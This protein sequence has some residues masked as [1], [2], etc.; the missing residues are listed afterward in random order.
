M[1][2]VGMIL[3]ALCCLV[4]AAFFCFSISHPSGNSISSAR[5]E[6]QADSSKMGTVVRTNT[7]IKKG[8]EITWDMLVEKPMPSHEIPPFALVLEVIPGAHANH[9]L[10]AGQVINANDIEP[11]DRTI[12]VSVYTLKDIPAGTRI[13]FGDVK[14]I[15][16]TGAYYA[17]DK[18]GHCT[19]VVGRTTRIRL[20][21]GQQVNDRVLFPEE[22]SA[23]YRHHP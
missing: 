6:L 9:D 3:I 13:Q 23:N 12:E 8:S 20:S 18:H 1:V 19:A 5:K 21:K 16:E 10:S 4:G 22:Q 14:S 11:N 2:K 17:V 15:P 7:D